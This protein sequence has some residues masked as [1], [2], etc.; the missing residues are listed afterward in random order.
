MKTQKVE[1]S[2]IQ[3]KKL[4][5]EISIDNESNKVLGDAFVFKGYSPEDAISKI[6]TQFDLL[7]ISAKVS[8]VKVEA[9]SL[10]SKQDTFYKAYKDSGGAMPLS[11]YLEG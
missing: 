3:R 7:G 8:V 10:M 11:I 2:I 9:T 1:A 4:E 5:F 6:V